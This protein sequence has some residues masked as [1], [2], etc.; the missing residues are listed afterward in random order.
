MFYKNHG[1]CNMA[2]IRTENL[3]KVFPG[4]QLGTEN[5]VLDGIN[6]DI[7][8]GE[9]FGIIGRSGAGKS[10]LVR[11]INYLEKPTAGEIW[12]EDTK[13]SGLTQKELYKARQS[14]GMIFQQFNLFMQRDALRNVCYPMEIAGWDKKKARAH[15]AELLELVGMG[16]KIHAYPTQLS[17]GQRQRVAIA[18]AIALDPKILLCDEATSALDPETTRDV[19]ALLKDINKKLNITCVVITHEMS[20][21]EQ[22]ADRV[23]ILDR[24]GVAEEGPVTEVFTSPKSDTAKGFIYPEGELGALTEMT[25]KNHIRI[26]FKGNSSF[27]PIIAGMVLRFRQHVNILYADTKDVGGKA[28]GQMLLQIPDDPFVA[29]AMT[30]YLKGL[31]LETEEVKGD[32]YA[33]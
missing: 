15:A 9:I 24:S 33:H 3:K 18:R 25:D 19:L 8:T 31:G 32:V 17:G 7:E 6:I 10:T 23:A 2:I 12:F 30:G 27:E 14:M 29:A 5:I 21:I 1:G 16:E 20:V 26:V 28:Y 11:C 13:L 4:P 22:I